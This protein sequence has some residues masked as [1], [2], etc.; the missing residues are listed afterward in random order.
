MDFEPGILQEE[1][2]K[3]HFVEIEVDEE[4]EFTSDGEGSSSEEELPVI[5]VRNLTLK[6]LKLK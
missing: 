4:L 2:V 5:E 1:E 3:I 6:E